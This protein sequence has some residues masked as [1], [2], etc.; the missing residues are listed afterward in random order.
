MM[1]KPIDMTGQ[2][3][4]RLT[5][6]EMAGRNKH[7]QRLWRCVCDC[8]KDAEV[9]G[10]LLRQGQTQSCGCLHREITANI[11]KT[12]GKSKSK[13][14]SIHRSMMDRCYLKTSHAYFRYGGRGITVCD[15]WHDFENFYKDMGDKPD[16]MSLERTDNN[17]GYS[18]DNVR[19][20]SAKD[21]AN[22]TRGNVRLELNG[23]VQTMQQW[24]D[25]LGLKIGTVWAR[26]NKYGYS[27]EKA[28]TKGWRANNAC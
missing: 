18:P 4:G 7:N 17:K 27:V 2:K 14:W 21:Q 13:I 6:I 8:G 11:N 28:L 20:A 1:G 16:G 23:R 9:L 12:H 25:E 5:V 26:L 19:W 15:R 3:H 24:C 10:F 22:N